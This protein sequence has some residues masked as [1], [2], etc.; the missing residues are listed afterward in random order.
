MSAEQNKT[1]VRR[2]FEEGMNQRNLNIF[3]ELL[4]PNYVNHNMPTPA[5]GTEGFKQVIS[6]FFSAFPDFH[7]T[8]EQVIAE[9]DK[10]ATRGTWRGTHK[11]DFM[12]IPATGKSVA[13][14]YSDIWR[15]ENGRAVENWVQMDMLGLMQQLGVAPAPG[16]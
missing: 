3:D 8:V 10:V 13:V 5:P 16:S 11:G 2:G 12:G 4:N 1:L 15:V 6:M 7:V 9:G 14:S